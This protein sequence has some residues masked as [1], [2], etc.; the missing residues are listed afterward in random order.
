MNIIFFSFYENGTRISKGPA[1]QMLYIRANFYF[2]SDKF[3]VYRI[4]MF[5]GVFLLSAP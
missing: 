3:K 5:N 4:G 1:K 2:N